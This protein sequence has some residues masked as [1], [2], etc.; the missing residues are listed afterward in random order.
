MWQSTKKKK[1]SQGAIKKVMINVAEY[2]KKEGFLRYNK[3]K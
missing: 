1:A 3:N 2:K